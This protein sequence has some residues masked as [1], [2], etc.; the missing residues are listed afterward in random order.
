MCELAELVEAKVCE[1]LAPRL[2][3]INSLRHLCDLALKFT[4]GPFWQILAHLPLYCRRF[5]SRI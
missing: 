4:S 5:E 1:M 3:F 2:K